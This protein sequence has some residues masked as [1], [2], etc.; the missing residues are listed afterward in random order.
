MNKNIDFESALKEL[1]TI[2]ERLEIG[3]CSLE[4]SIKLYEKGIEL[5]KACADVLKQ[6]KQKIIT[7]EE[8][9]EENQ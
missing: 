2:S 7:L 8:A 1:E 9:E 6:A 3:E 4:E 5:S